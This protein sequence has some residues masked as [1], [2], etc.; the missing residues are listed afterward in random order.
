MVQRVLNLVATGGKLFQFNGT[1]FRR[2]LCRL[3]TLLGQNETS[4]I[5]LK[6]SRAGRATSLAASGLS[7]GGILIAGEWKSSAILRYC[8]VDDLSVSASSDHDDEK[9][10]IDGV[11]GVRR[12][13]TKKRVVLVVLFSVPPCGL[14]VLVRC[15]WA[16]LGAGTVDHSGTYP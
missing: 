9:P 3:L 11:C 5:T 8:Q 16:S 4:Q 15:R 6:G 1:E 14:V 10:C 13:N 7:I 2:V 12:K